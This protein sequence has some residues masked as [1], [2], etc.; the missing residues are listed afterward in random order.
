[1]LRP[2]IL[3]ISTSSSG[4][5]GIAATRLHYG[6]LKQGMNSKILF[7]QNKKTV[8]ES[9]SFYQPPGLLQRTIHKIGYFKPQ[10]EKNKKKLFGK[11]AYKSDMFT[12]PKTDFNINTHSS[13][14]NADI[15]N[16]HWIADFVD[17][18][19]FF[20]KIDKPI[21]WTLH[22]QNPF[23]G[24]CHYSY[25]CKKF[26]TDCFNCP[27]LSGTSNLN[28]AHENLFVKQKLFRK[29]NKIIIVAPSKWLTAE[30]QKSLLFNNL[31]CFTIP[32]GLNT[33]LY[34]PLDK[35]SSQK[36]FNIP[37]NKKVILFISDKLGEE[38]KGFLFVESLINSFHRNDVI[39][40]A[41][42]TNKDYIQNEK[43]IFTGKIE[44]EETLAKAYNAA[45]VFLLP[46]L[47]D[48]LPN[49]M[50]ESLSC[51]T[52]VIGFPVGGISDFIISG[53][54]GILAPSADSSALFNSLRDFLN[55]VYAFD[56]AIIRKFALQKFN[57]AI[58]ASHYRKI[59]EELLH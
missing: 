22:D 18:K 9:Y 44:D 3:H 39:F 7:L 33:E 12:F 56:T 10:T 1:M 50:I 38:R 28:M 14:K 6:L 21:V 8:P 5:A 15:I 19:S 42:G 40:L 35:L 43:V 23:T 30:A 11:S 48:N 27:Q 54:T 47:A 16:L 32:Y 26:E 57:I 2:N 17:Y 34:K 29:N 59:Y 4:G 31:K 49:T 58:Q 45:D 20:S 55:D 51:G 13:L 37:E 36:F 53:R 25:D 41:I 24:G 46:S 52:P